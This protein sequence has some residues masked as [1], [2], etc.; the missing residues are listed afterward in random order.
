MDKDLW[1]VLEEENHR[2]QKLKKSSRYLQNQSKCSKFSIDMNTNPFCHDKQR[3]D[4][5][6][7]QK[8][9]MKFLS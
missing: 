6:E 5:K 3:R 1:R 4:W 7:L 8:R 9:L 2:F